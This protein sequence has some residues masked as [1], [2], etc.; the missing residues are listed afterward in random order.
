M[1]SEKDVS[2]WKSNNSGRGE[3]KSGTKI[4]TDTDNNY[5]DLVTASEQ[6]G[7]HTEYRAVYIT[8]SHATEKMTECK[9]WMSSD[10]RST[11]F[12]H[13]EW[14]IDPV[15]VHP[16]YPFTYSPYM[17][18]VDEYIELGNQA[19]LWSQALTKFSFTI[20]IFPT[21]AGDG[22]DRYVFHHGATSNHGKR[23]AVDSSDPTK[24][25]FFIK[26]SLGTIMTAFSTGLNLNQWNFIAC[27]YDS[28]L[29]SDNLKIYVNNVLG[30]QTANLTETINLSATAQISRDVNP[31]K[32]YTKDFRWFNGKALTT[33]QIDDIYTGE[34]DAV[35]ANYWLKM[36]DAWTNTD[37]DDSISGTL[38][39][40]FQNGTEGRDIQEIPSSTTSPVGMTWLGVTSGP[41]PGSPNIG[42]LTPV[43]D[44][45]CPFWVKWIVE[46]GEEDAAADFCTFVLDGKI[47]SSGTE[48]PGE[49]PDDP[50]PTPEPVASD[51][52]F[53]ACGDWGTES[54][55]GKVVA[56]I[57]DNSPKP[58]LVCGLGDNAYGT[59]GD[60][61]DFFDYIDPIDGK[62]GIVFKTAF[63]NHDNAE[64]ESSDN[65]TKMKNHFGLSKTY[66]TF[67]MQN[68][69]FI[70]I[71][72]TTETS[73]SKGSSQYNDVANWLKTGR[74]KTN[75]D[76]IVVF[77]HKPMF[78]GNSKHDYNDDN[79][80]QAMWPLFDQYKVD[81][82]LFGHN[83][84]MAQSKQVVYNSNSPTSPTIKDSSTP[85]T[86][87]VGR[88]HCVVGTGGHDAS[89]LYEVSSFSQTEWDNDTD[90]GALFVTI[91]NSAGTTTL[92]GRF[93]S[94]DKSTLRT[95]VITR[96]T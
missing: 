59:G 43:D 55:T 4:V 35:G 34:S 19:G 65:E 29:G 8:D 32:G 14:G 7:G 40:T 57:K 1:V 61:D 37:V 22:T 49:D 89:D 90:H 71:D 81:L 53:A 82:M 48:S 52:T 66:Y 10:N 95:F 9:L 41:I 78:G 74:E 51:F 28:T 60:V 67:D 56:L 30:S 39:G 27:V 58:A 83:H 91:T 6:V 21:A 42:T 75:I 87:G 15:S 46:D 23:L 25:R 18:G 3:S 50:S 96:T 47:P 5:F 20:W 79:F 73:F 44:R 68:V 2:W 33:D 80:N 93:K 13:V 69:R 94:I 64:S 92:T 76:W 77:A 88:I 31:F 12:S 38:T 26:D 45:Q 72:N 54:M 24:I 62:N 84:H 63:G 11:A 16:L 36:T 86:G 70:V 85:Y 17:D